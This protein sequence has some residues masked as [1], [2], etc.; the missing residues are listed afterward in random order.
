[1]LCVDVVRTLL[2][3]IIP[4]SYRGATIRYL[5]YARCSLSGQYLALE[6]GQF[7]GESIQD[8]TQLVSLS[9]FCKW[10]LCLFHYISF[11]LILKVSVNSS[12]AVQ[13]VA[14]DLHI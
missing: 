1:M 7:P 11:V 2:P 14:V 6:N 4:P 8:L 9:V 10:Y 13:N 5:Y 3:S 12:S